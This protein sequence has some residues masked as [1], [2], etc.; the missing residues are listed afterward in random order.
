MRRQRSWE[1][2]PGGLDSGGMKEVVGIRRL[3][4]SDATEAVAA[5]GWLVCEPPDAFNE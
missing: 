1:Q 2:S 3:K 4:K 5:S